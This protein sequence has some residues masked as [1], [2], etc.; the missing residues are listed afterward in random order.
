MNQPDLTAVGAAF[1]RASHLLLDDPPFVHEDPLSIK[2]VD[3]DLLRSVQLLADDGRLKVRRDDPRAK[4]RGIFVGRARYVEDCIAERAADGVRQYVILG[5]GLDTFAQRRT[6][7][8]SQMRV[9]EV[10]EPGTQRWKQARL[11]K[12]G[13]DVP[14]N[15]Q[16]VPVDFEEGASWVDA[17]AASGFDRDE[18]AVISSTGVTQYITEAALNSTLQ[19]AA[20]LGRGTTFIS[21]FILPADRIDPGE[22]ELRGV[23]EERAAARGAPWI[24][25]YAPAVI[26]SMAEAAGF[27]RVA[28][29]SQDELN[30]RYFSDRADGLRA[31]SGEQLIVATQ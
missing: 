21:T 30:E 4:W 31:P 29:V 15:L 10:D 27:K 12:L 17:I 9:F 26:V 25:C 3:R 24:S 16:F 28:H 20:G 22:R 23:T 8:M 1:G 19:D 7:L 2:L 6:E 14:P 5:A 13:M 11:R 18:P